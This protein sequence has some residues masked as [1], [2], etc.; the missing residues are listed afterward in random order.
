MNRSVAF[1]KACPCINFSFEGV[2]G[3]RNTTPILLLITIHFRI[4]AAIPKQPCT[5]FS[6]NFKKETISLLVLS[7]SATSMASNPILRLTKG[8]D[9][10]RW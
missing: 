5:Y 8:W 4:N 7:I 6:A 2:Y 3:Q 9:N 1:L 10:T